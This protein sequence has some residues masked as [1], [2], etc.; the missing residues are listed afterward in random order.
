M[1]IK[2]LDE[3]GYKTKTVRRRFSPFPAPTESRVTL[4]VVDRGYFL[5]YYGNRTLFDKHRA[6]KKM[7][8]KI[9]TIAYDSAC[10]EDGVQ[11]FVR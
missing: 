4:A 7:F 3:K 11:D 6:C 10:Y 8:S 9:S 2:N 1:T 5:E